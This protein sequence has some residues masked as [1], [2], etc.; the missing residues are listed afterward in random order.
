MCGRYEIVDGKQIF[1]RF[2]VANTAPEMLANLDVRPTQ[3]VPVLLTDHQLQLMKWGLVPPW[4][5]DMSIGNKMIN[6][7]SEG[8][9]TKPSFKRPLRTQRCLLPASAFFEWKGATGATEVKGAKTKYRIGRKDGDMFG[10]AGLYDVWKS[11]SG[12]EVTTC[13]IITCAPNAVM[14]PIHNR[15]PVI[16]LPEDE[17][18]WLDPDMIEVEAITSYLRPYPDELLEAVKAA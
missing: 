13:T 18:V 3:Q 15:M 17:E 10:L 14:A 2:G 8:I 6:A 12:Y 4:A 1:V 9:E 5:K 11:P 16:L 7:R